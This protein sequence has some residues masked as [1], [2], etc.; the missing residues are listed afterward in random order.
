[1]TKRLHSHPHLFLGEHIEQVKRALQGILK[2]HST[3]TITP[4]IKE[5]SEKVVCL[6]DL[7]KGTRAFQDYIAD[8]PKYKG[9]PGEKAHTPLSL[10]FSL[11]YARDEGWE[12]LETLLLAAVV[13]GH[14]SRLPTIPEKKIGGVGSAAW[15]I[16]NFAGGERARILINQLNLI[17]YNALI[18]EA[19]IDFTNITKSGE[20]S[21]DSTKLLLIAKK[22]LINKVIPKFLNVDI[23]EAVDYRLKTQLVFSMLLEADKAFLAVSNPEQYLN[24]E[25]KDWQAN[26]VDQYI[27]TPSDTFTN[28]LRQKARFDIDDSINQNENNKIYSLT[29]PTGI[30]KTL[31]AATWALKL[32]EIIS[33][34]SG[35][36]PKIIIVLPYLS[37]IDQTA[38]IYGDLLKTGGVNADGAWLLTSHSLSDREYADWLE[39]E[40]KPFFVDTW[41][42]ELIITTYDQFLMSLMDPRSR[43]QMRFHNLCDALIIMDEVQSL[44]CKLW[45]PLD[46]IFKSLVN[47]GN[48]RIL[49]MSATLPPFVSEAKPLLPAFETYFKKFERYKLCFRLESKL[50]LEHFCDELEDRLPFWLKDKK[51]VLITLNT[52]KSARKIR[53]ALDSPVLKES[54]YPIYFISADVTPKDRLAVIQKIKKG[55]PC[56]VVST[57]CIEAGVDIDMDI[58]IRDFAPLDS[59]IQI[60][61]RCNREGEKERCTVVVVDLV[62]ENNKSYA[63]MIYDPTHLQSTRRLVDNISEI[64]EEQAL[65]FANRFFKELA[66]KKDTGGIHL[67]RF[68]RWREDLPVHEILRGKEKKQ[69]TFLVIDQDPSLK[70]DMAKANQEEDRWK[71]REAWRELAGRIAMVSVS[72]YARPQ[73]NPRQIAIEHLGHWLLREGYYSNNRGLLVEGET[74]IL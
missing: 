52:R 4:Q 6:H 55:N 45:Q 1:M 21:K 38:K 28:H 71:R 30:G 66:I 49:M 18:K 51:R 31:L 5:L 59:L 50:S 46:K 19:G 35:T 64:F 72:I 24:R 14:H 27:G 43:Y 37:V 70:E 36:T 60:S 12:E 3:N 26:W 58:V 20:L 54:G 33:A 2:W 63:E 53:D 74:M 10:V 16:D 67:E 47:I 11:A 65:D 25:V 68:A 13:K 41:R 39:D 44:P 61:G 9:D 32:R 48:S 42:S 15:D 73:F 23:D 29:A 69:Y 17:D 8:P 7:G 34:A 62:D 22:L 56:I 57:Q 40:D